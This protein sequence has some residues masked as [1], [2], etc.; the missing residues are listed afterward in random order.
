MLPLVIS[1]GWIFADLASPVTR[2]EYSQAVLQR[3]V[4]HKPLS[5]E[6]RHYYLTKG[7]FLAGFLRKGMTPEEVSRVLGV[8]PN[9]W[10]QA[11]GDWWDTYSLLGL[12]VRYSP[13]D[14]AAPGG[15]GGASSS[16]R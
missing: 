10:A 9:E 4:S 14:V 15:G 2:A 8:P 13:A 5:P 3:F 11:H 7:R 6:V 16:W 12:T 1:A